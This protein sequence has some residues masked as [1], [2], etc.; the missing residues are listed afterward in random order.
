LASHDVEGSWT[1]GRYLALRRFGGRA[2]VDLLAAIEAHEGHLA[3]RAS[4]LTTRQLEEEVAFV[5]RNL[6]ISEPRVRASLHDGALSGGSKIELSRLARA[7]VQR[8]N[9]VPF[10][11]ATLGGARIAVRPDQVTAARVAYRTAL[12]AI[13]FGGSASIS[14]ITA[15]LAG[16]PSGRI[17]ATFAERLFSN[18]VTFRW[19]DRAAGVFWFAGAAFPTS[20]PAHPAVSRGGASTRARAG[21]SAG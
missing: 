16:L 4:S 13:A 5:L 12:R 7:W 18:L 2:I 21:R 6:P 3:R 1:L 19:V 20:T 14:E 17:D 15:Q 9:S 11:V 8:G 10:R